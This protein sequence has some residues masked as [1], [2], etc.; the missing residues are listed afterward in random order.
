MTEL[1]CRGHTVVPLKVI[2]PDFFFNDKLNLQTSF[3]NL[4]IVKELGAGAFG[5]ISEAL[6][7]NELV[8]VKQLTI[9]NPDAR[10]EAFR[11]WRHEVNVMRF[12]FFSLANIF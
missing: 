2:V 11:D 5:T 9:T 7:N 10:L 12:V 4:K 6:L 8:A 1:K 3:S